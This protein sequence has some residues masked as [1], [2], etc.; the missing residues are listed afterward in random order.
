MR[1]TFINTLLEESKN[2]KNIIL[3]TADLGY[4][5]VEEYM[6]KLP[7]QYLNVGISEQNMTG[8]AAGMAMEGRLPIIYSIIPFV[9]MRN[10]EQIRNDICYQ[11]MN[12][13]IVGVGAG[14][15][16]GPYGH[17][18]H[19]LEDIGILRMLP[20]LVILTPGDPIE[21]KLATQAMLHHTGPVYL[22][23]GKKGEPN[24][25]SKVPTF[26]IG[27]GIV[28]QDGTDITIFGT[29]TMLETASQVTKELKRRNISV[30]LISI[31]TVK[32]IDEKL[33]LASAKK[34]KNI[35]TIEEH[36]IIGGL[37]SALAE[38]LAE[39]GL[40]YKFK[41]FG[42]PDRFTKEIGLQDYMRGRNGL[43][44]MQ[45]TK[46]ITHLLEKK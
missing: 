1:N 16:Y 26:T 29:S 5:V 24:I 8:M 20:N 34:T 9:T 19:A 2:N 23:I 28:L 14:F 41:R 7:R 18:H 37:G 40:A 3:L 33:I 39:S 43:L 46:A 12:V 32:P 21:V 11:N 25:H 35:V 27:R 4:S 30:Q 36:S 17:T 31:H 45:I 38:V 22:R 42:V 13:K 44:P 10:F 6:D 15:S